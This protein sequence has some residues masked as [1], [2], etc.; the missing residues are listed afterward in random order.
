MFDKIKADNFSIGIYGDGLLFFDYKLE[1]E[2]QRIKAA[3]RISLK[4]VSKCYDNNDEWKLGIYGEWHLTLIV[5][6][7]GTEKIV[8]LGSVRKAFEEMVS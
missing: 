2:E 3:G 1:N 8:S 7:K 4:K 6:L 5:T